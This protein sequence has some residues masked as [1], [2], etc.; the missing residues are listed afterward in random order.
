MD[1]EN[2]KPIELEIKAIKKSI[3][4]GFN[5][6]TPPEFYAK[7]KSTKLKR[8]RHLIELLLFISLVVLFLI[9][10]NNIYYIF[11]TEETMFNRILLSICLVM[12]IVCMI[13]IYKNIRTWIN[14]FEIAKERRVKYEKERTRKL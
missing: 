7:W 13:A 5:G 4:L 9:T 10:Y 6:E 3:E 2:S 1:K 11:Q 8:I 12:I 14:M